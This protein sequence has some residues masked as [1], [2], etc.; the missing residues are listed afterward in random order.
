MTSSS[1]SSAHW[2]QPESDPN[3]QGPPPLPTTNRVPGT[4]VAVALKENNTPLLGV[5][6]GGPAGLAHGEGEDAGEVRE[7]REEVLPHRA[8]AERLGNRG[9][10]FRLSFKFSAS[11]TPFLR[12]AS[13]CHEAKSSVTF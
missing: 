12:R 13:R 7:D 10:S 4:R 2:Q 3:C 11:C 1:R 5:W 9:S 6:G 8:E